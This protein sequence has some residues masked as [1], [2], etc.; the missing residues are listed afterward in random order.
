[1]AEEIKDI[2]AKTGV[3][4]LDDLLSGGIPKGNL[5]M[6]TGS[7]G[8]G[9]TILGL[10][11]LI[12]GAKKG[13]KSLYI[14]LN[15]PVEN[16]KKHAKL[17]GLNLEEYEKKDLLKIRGSSHLEVTDPI[18]D[19]AHQVSNFGANRLVIDPINVLGAYI[20][21]SQKLRKKILDLNETLTMHKCTTFTVSE[22]REGSQHI[23][24]YGIEEFVCD[25]I[26]ILYYLKKKDTYERAICVRK[27]RG[28]NHSKEIRPMS[29][30]YGGIKV[31]PTEEFLGVKL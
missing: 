21:S 19:I 17:V 28:S 15:E 4:G 22:T 1:M 27:M 30:S 12:E 8:T 10:S 13:E 9:K 31:F 20:G 29:I 5:V 2:R 26:I 18:G 14:S 7:P 16:I 6:I 24:A 23:S 25:G 3:F 11:F